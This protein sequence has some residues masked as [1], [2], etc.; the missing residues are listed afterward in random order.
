MR[1]SELYQRY[2]DQI[3]GIAKAPQRPSEWRAGVEALVRQFHAETMA[4]ARGPFR[5]ARD[6]MSA[7]LAA[8]ASS[9]S[10]DTAREVFSYAADLIKKL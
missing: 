10:Q 1:T 9:A 7:E 5:R 4:M 6:D 8:K 2:I 3:I